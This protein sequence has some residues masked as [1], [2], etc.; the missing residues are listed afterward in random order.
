M[1]F[2][3][4]AKAELCRVETPHDC[5]R[6]AECYG[7][8]LFGGSFSASSVSFLTESAPVARRAA[9]EAAAAIGVF[10]ESASAVVRR[11]GKTT[12][13]VSC[14]LYTSFCEKEGQFVLPTENIVKICK[15]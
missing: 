14:L 9:Q 8:F 6:A 10:V 15:D 7:L 13:S 2:S 5:C 3:S 12:F 11:G 1:S 4:E